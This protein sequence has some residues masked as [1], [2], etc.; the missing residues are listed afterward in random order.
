MSLKV[1][2]DDFFRDM[3]TFGGAL[4][5]LLVFFILL[6]NSINWAVLFA[7]GIIILMGVVI[8]IRLVYFKARPRKQ[9]FNSIIEKID[10][11][12]FPSLH[13]AR[14]I[15]IAIFVGLMFSVGL[16][17][18]ALMMSGAL[19]VGYSRIYMQKHDWIDV[20]CGW[21]LGIM[22][23]FLLFK[24]NFFSFGLYFGL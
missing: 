24:L 2:R 4:F 20:V 5:S 14:A 16:L 23:G 6:I 1:V 10:A 21:M 15:F 12:S 22:V 19:M 18:W 11:S 17:S 13:A 8:G 9:Q 3:T 7:G